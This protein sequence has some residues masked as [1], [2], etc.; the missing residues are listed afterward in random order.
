[1]RSSRSPGRR[2]AKYLLENDVAVLLD[3]H[4][5]HDG[6]EIAIYIRMRQKTAHMP[7]IFPRHVE[8]MNTSK[9][10]SLGAVDIY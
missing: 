7:I 2:G 5:R 4:A 9:G 1:M 8:E 6:L 3:E 10:Y